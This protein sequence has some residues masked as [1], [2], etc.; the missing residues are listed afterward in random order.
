MEQIGSFIYILIL[1]DL[2]IDIQT[3]RP[4]ELNASLPCRIM[5][6]GARTITKHLRIGVLSVLTMKRRAAT[7]FTVHTRTVATS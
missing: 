7:Q 4:K 6:T 3:L 5:N 2:F 1:H